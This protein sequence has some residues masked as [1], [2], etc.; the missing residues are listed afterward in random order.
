MPSVER[1]TAIL[2]YLT[3]AREKSIASANERMVERILD[4]PARLTECEK[5][6]A[7]NLACNTTD[8]WDN[9]TDTRIVRLATR[10][11]WARECVVGLEDF[12]KLRQAFGR[13][14]LDWD[15]KIVH[16]ADDNTVLVPLKF[17]TELKC[18]VF[19]SI[20]TIPEDAKCKIVK[21]SRIVEDVAIV[22]NMKGTK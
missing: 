18:F 19:K 1:T 10:E 6:E 3:E 21:S 11:Q 8:S 12:R 13:V 5:V 16:N 4:F 20:E 2:T 22:C 7:L 17:E 14:E 15:Y 9:L